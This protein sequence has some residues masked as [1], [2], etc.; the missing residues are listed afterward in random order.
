MTLSLHDVPGSFGIRAYFPGHLTAG[1]DKECSAGSAPFRS[2][3]TGV[4]WIPSATVTGAD[5]DYFT[6]T[7]YNRGAAGAGTTAVATLAFVS[8]VNATG[9]APKTIVVSVTAA[10][11][12]LADGDCLSVKKTAAG[13]GLA[14]PDGVI[15]VTVK[16]R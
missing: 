11:L 8:G 13:T 16:A 14:C 5:T 1:T 4:K 9:N 7:V 12:D 10:D 3:V 15:V 2:T 6:L